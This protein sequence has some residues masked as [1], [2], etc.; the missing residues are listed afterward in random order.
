MCVCVCA[1]LGQETSVFSQN[2]AVF[3]VAFVRSHFFRFRACFLIQFNDRANSA[4]VLQRIKNRDG[5]IDP[6]ESETVFCK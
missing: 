3:C 1:L 6:A 2:R 4:Q 5:V